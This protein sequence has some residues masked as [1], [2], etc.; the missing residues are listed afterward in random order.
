MV[1][2]ELI[3]VLKNAVER[4]ESIENVIQ[5]FINA[6][7][8]SQE[9]NEA[10]SYLNMGNARVA[11]KLENS[12][13]TNQQQT[14]QVQQIQQMQEPQQ[15]LPQLPQQNPQYFPQQAQQ[16]S[17]QVQYI[18]FQQA[19][20]QATQQAQQ[21]QPQIQ[22]Q[23]AMQQMPVQGNKE[24]TKRKIPGVII[25]LIVLLIILIGFFAFFY[26]FGENILSSMFE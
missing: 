1:R 17:T 8:S 16:Q 2:E 19:Q 3:G 22:Q 5:T 10:A 18:P 15:S 26:F 25:F 9:V 23:Q 21:A 4:G 14:I 20:Q 7:Y 24:K 11:G 13:I 12:Q 6:G